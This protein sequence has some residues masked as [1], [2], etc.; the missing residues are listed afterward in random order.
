[1]YLIY[2]CG[3]M[4]MF[5]WVCVCEMVRCT[6]LTSGKMFVFYSIVPANNI[7][8]S[9]FV[10]ISLLLTCE[11]KQYCSEIFVSLRRF[12]SGFTLHFQVVINSCDKQKNSVL[13]TDF[14]TEME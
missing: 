13:W 5:L 1:M 6:E 12:V 4:C 10:K 8:Y 7:Y 14:Y 2:L 9:R 11:T 3:V